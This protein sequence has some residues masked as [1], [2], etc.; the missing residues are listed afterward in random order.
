MCR[1]A[2]IEKAAPGVVGRTVAPRGA[3]SGEPSPRQA[4]THGAPPGSRKGEWART[5]GEVLAAVLE[6]GQMELEDCGE[7]RR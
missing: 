4:Q 7:L 1:K 2:N 3:G 6:L 5:E